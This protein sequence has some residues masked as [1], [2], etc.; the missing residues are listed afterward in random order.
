MAGVGNDGGEP[1]VVP[2]LDETVTDDPGGSVVVLATGVPSVPSV[3][4][5]MVMVACVD[6]TAGC[7]PTRSSIGVAN[8]AAVGQQRV[9]AGS[10]LFDGRPGPGW[11]RVRE[12][13]RRRTFR[14]PV[15]SGTWIEP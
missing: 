14:M 1:S 3:V 5:M 9:M 10:F 13:L 15:A 11:P 4:M 6:A 12:G 7:A 2:T 8:R